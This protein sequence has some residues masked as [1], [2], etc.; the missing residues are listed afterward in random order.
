[1]VDIQGAGGL[2]E[3]GEAGPVDQQAGECQP[4]LFP[5]GQHVGP[6]QHRVEPADTFG[7]I[8]QPHRFEDLL[9]RSFR[10][11]FSSRG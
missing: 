6:I 11:S 2:V 9:Q 1:L 10:Q 5:Q 8:V 7:Q 4:L 3:H